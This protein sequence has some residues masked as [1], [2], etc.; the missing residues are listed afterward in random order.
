MRSSPISADP[1]QIVCLPLNLPL[2]IFLARDNHQQ[3]FL[4]RWGKYLYAMSVLD[5]IRLIIYRFHEK[6]L[7]VFMI[8]QEDVC[9]CLPAKYLLDEQKN[10]LIEL[11]PVDHEGQRLQAFAIE[12]DWHEIPSIRQLIK[13]DV[14]VVTDKMLERTADLERGTY[15]AIKDAIKKSMPHEYSLLKELKEI[16]VDRNLVRNI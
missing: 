5:S 6:G 4:F 14:R 10:K 3:R 8:N 7:E 15:I 9:C 13:Q 2:S 12:G 11:E 1:F 16:L